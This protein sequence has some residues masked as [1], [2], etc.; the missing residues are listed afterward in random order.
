MSN[1]FKQIVRIANRD[2][3]GTYQTHYAL[4]KIKGI[5]FNTAIAICRLAGID[6]LTKIGTLSDDEIKRLEDYVLNLHKKVPYPWFLNRQRDLFTNENMH[7]VESDLVYKVMEDI[8]FMSSIK[9]WK[10]IRHSMGLKVRGQSTRTTGRTGL[11]VGV[12]KKSKKQ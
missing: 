2:L 10:G 8:K 5:G 3:N 11:T 12:T 6:P 4:Q 9:S 7:L 1:N